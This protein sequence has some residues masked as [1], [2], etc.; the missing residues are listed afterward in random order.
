MRNVCLFFFEGFL[1]LFLNVAEG[2][3]SSVVGGTLEKF[4]SFCILVLAI[5][6]YNFFVVIF[7]GV[8]IKKKYEY[9][10]AVRKSFFLERF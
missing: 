5:F 1:N 6:C 9:E 10:L 2:G 7:L 8:K 4:N 3:S